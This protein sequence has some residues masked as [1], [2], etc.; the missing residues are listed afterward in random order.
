[1]KVLVIGHPEAVLGF[2]LAGVSG[3]VATSADEVNQA[4]DKALASTDTGI[5][6]VTQDVSRLIQARMDQLQLRSTIPLVVE[7]PGPA[8]VGPDQPSLSDV[9]LRAIGVTVGI[10][11]AS[12]F[13]LA[14]LL[15]RDAIFS[16]GPEG[17]KRTA[18]FIGGKRAIEALD[19]YKRHGVVAVTVSLQGDDPGYSASGI[20]RQNGFRYGR[21]GG[22]LVSAY[23]PDGS[24]K[25]ADDWILSQTLVR[26]GAALG[27]NS[28]ALR[29][30]HRPYRRHQL[31]RKRNSCGTRRYSSRDI[32]IG[33]CW[34]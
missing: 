8:G 30:A 9:V 19:V 7:I 24:L 13:V 20:S 16:R 5:V 15:T 21:E 33:R 28:F 14:L 12:N 34:R 4:L 29:P 25:A 17:I 23:R 32:R 11:V 27:A 2:S 10:G 22:T 31:K 18:M 1:M 6:L 26:K 3:Q